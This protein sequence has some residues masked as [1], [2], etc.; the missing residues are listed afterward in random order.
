MSF[1]EVELK[2]NKLIILMDKKTTQDDIV[3]VGLLLTGSDP[4]LQWE[5]DNKKEERQG[6]SDSLCKKEW[7]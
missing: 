7:V 5:N 4:D 1:N 6:K 3:S 2:S